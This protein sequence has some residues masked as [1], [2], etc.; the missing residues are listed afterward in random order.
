MTVREID[1]SSGGM[2]YALSKGS[3]YIFLD[4]VV[5]GVDATSFAKIDRSLL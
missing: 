4:Q 3:L 5:L 2:P 1:Q